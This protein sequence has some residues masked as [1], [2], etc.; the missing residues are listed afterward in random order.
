MAEPVIIF[1]INEGTEGTPTWVTTDVALRW[2]GPAGV[3][4]PFPAPVGDADDAFFDAA[5]APNDGEL[6]H[7]QTTD[8]QIT[9]AGRNTN[10]NVLRA[11]ETGG[12][13]P[14]ADPPEFT[15]YDD[16]TGGQNRTNPT[17]WILVGTAGSSNISQIRAIETTGGAPGAGWTGQVHDTAPSAGAALDGNK[18][19][20]K[21]V[22]ASALAASGNKLFNLA[23]CAPHDAT[24][25]LT[26]FIYQFQYTWT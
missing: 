24:A 11:R 1:E 12:T 14:T 18:S 5:A 16:V 3:G 19:G 13:D 7:D 23:A 6:W 8:A 15:A 4:D 22:C 20:E 9:V 25:G 10:I 17:V 26:N 21:V 2:T